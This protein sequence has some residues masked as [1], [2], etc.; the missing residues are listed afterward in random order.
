MEDGLVNDFIDIFSYQLVAVIFRGEKFFLTA[1]R[2][3]G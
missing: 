2:Q 3:G 1:L